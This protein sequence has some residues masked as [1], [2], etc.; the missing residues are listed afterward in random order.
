M[1]NKE[2]LVIMS[3]ML[4]ILVD[5]LHV[6][7]TPTLMEK[8]D[9]TSQ[10]VNFSENLMIRN[11]EYSNDSRVNTLSSSLFE[12]D[13]T[14][15]AQAEFV[16]LAQMKKENLSEILEMTNTSDW[17][18][19]QNSN[20]IPVSLFILTTA[21][22]THDAQPSVAT[23]TEFGNNLIEI[24]ECIERKTM[25]AEEIQIKTDASMDFHEAYV[26]IASPAQ[27]LSPVVPEPS[28]LILLGSG[29]ILLFG[30]VRRFR[31]KRFNALK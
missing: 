2:Y 31:S 22:S 30:L 26:T 21:E 5:C 10:F 19:R 8:T 3:V 17:Y 11:E 9:F 14:R 7:A 20:L 1:K 18:F 12:P 24:S 28:T 6:F 23:H 27:C 13:V 29:L 4:V 25:A 15:T 16:D